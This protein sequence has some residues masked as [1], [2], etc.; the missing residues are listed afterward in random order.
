V[1]SGISGR[2]FPELL[3]AFKGFS[4]TTCFNF[5]HYVQKNN[6]FLA[7]LPGIS[8]HLNEN[9]GRYNFQAFGN[10]SGNMKFPEKLQ[11]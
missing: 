9:Y 4:S 8:A 5:M 3:A 2:K 1:S 10:M 7:R 6:L 11:P